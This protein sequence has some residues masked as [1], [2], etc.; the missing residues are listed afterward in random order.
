MATRTMCLRSCVVAVLV[1]VGRSH[2]QT[3]VLYVT[4]G[5][6]DFIKAIQGGSIVDQNSSTGGSRRYRV[7]V[8][9]TIWLGDMDSGTNA[10]FDLALDPT[11]NTSPTGVDITEGT[12]G[13]TDGVHNFTVESFVSTGTVYQYDGNWSG[14]TPLFSVTGDQIVGITYDTSAD[15]LWVSD[16]FTVAQYDMAGN[17]LASFPHQ[18]DRGSLAY[19]HATDTL[20]YVTNAPSNII[21][22]YAKDGTLLQTLNVPYGGNVWGAEFQFAG[23]PPCFS[24]VSEEVVC[25]ADGTTF[26]LTVDGIDAC[27]GGMSTYTF[28]A[29]GGAVGEELCFTVLVD[30]GGFCCSTEICVT[31]PDCTG[32][33]GVLEI[34]TIDTGDSWANSTISAIPGHNVTTI[35]AAGIGGIDFSLFDVLYVTDAYTNPST[36]TW[37]SALIAR[38]PDI[39]TYING[40]GFVI[41][42]VEGFGGD[43]ITNGDEYNF[44]PSGLVDGNTVGTQVF[45]NDVVITDPTHPLFDGITSADLSDWF[46]SYHGSLPVGTLPVLATNA[47]GQ[48]L[49][50]GGSVGAG[51]V[52]V[53]S[54]DPD[55]HFDIP[56]TLALVEN[57][58]G[59]VQAAQPVIP[60]DLNG[61]GLVGIVDFRALLGAW[62]SCLDCG[63]CPADF[64][65]DCSVGILD[66]LIL[67]GNWG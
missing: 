50:R 12:D 5:D 25:H 34:L 1:I 56:G 47:G 17:V 13:A 53:W 37:A 52:F 28:T 62:G 46:A 8:R 49:I 23:E 55:F 51:G 63:N 54:L 35:T 21:R 11:G 66:L 41:V 26:T 60:S 48:V 43:S 58:I 10:E 16:R 32:G 19:E 18:G 9:D 44:L 61:A 59:L 22:Q 31:I 36:P 42:G 29:S 24:V 7:A 33:T 40:G 6:S 2:A 38:G 14:G 65:G 15:T 64:D 39:D 30:D 45:G 20:W 3:S 67:L 57:A 27:T 4:D